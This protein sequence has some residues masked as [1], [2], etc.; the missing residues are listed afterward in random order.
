MDY[1]ARDV[2]QPD[3]AS[4]LD[5]SDLLLTIKEWV[6]ADMD[7]T[8]AWRTQARK[9]FQFVAGPGQWEA[10]DAQIL[11]DQKRP[12]ITFNRTLKFIRAICGLEVNNRQ[13]TTYLPRD[14][15]NEGEVKAN[16]LLTNASDW[17][18]QGCSA[19]RQQSRAFRDTTIC[20]MGWTEGALDYDED[21]KGKYVETRCNP[22]EMGWDCNSRDANLHDAKR[23]WRVREMTL[24]EAQNLIPGVTDVEGLFPEDLDASWADVSD[25]PTGNPK[26]QEQKELREEG[27]IDDSPKRK[28]RIVQIQ[29]WEHEKYILTVNPQTGQEVEVDGDQF[30][31]LSAQYQAVYGI[32]L[33]KSELRRKVYKQA[34]VGGKILSVGPCPRAD[35]FTFNCITGEPEDIEGTFY[36]MVRVFRDPQTYANKF[37]SQ[38]MHIVNTTAKGGII[39]EAD[40]FEDVRDAMKSYAKPDAVTVVRPGAIS[41]GKIMPKPGGALTGGVLQLMQIVDAMF[42]EVSGMNVE[43]MGMA[44]RQQPGVL[45]AQRKQ[46]AMTILATLFD[47]LSQFRQD[48]GRM[49]LFYIQNYLADG[50]LIRVHGED[51][52]KAIPLLQDQTLGRYDVV[53]D[54]APSSVNAKEKAW[55]ALMM[56]LPTVKDMLTPEVVTMLL[57]Y[58]PNLP[59]RVVDQLK[60]IASRPPPEPDP[61]V[62]AIQKAAEGAKIEKDRASAQQSRSAAV[63][64]FAKAGVER[65]QARREAVDAELIGAGLMDPIDADEQVMGPAP[66]PPPLPT[67]TEPMSTPMPEP[68]PADSGL[69]LPG[70]LMGAR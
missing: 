38:L 4:G 33:P 62:V 2:S 58:V 7:H 68:M 19:H 13:M 59:T 48:V 5:D 53:V 20:G 66:M 3:G 63:L 29:W 10:D 43:L 42:A 67:Q 52:H 6:K 39:A 8:S 57:D 22:L 23:R 32:P 11:T 27:S 21:P 30:D 44:D 1:T 40:A 26:T 35:G 18:S 70:G 12:I 65:A 41:K 51:G 61:E 45:E 31:G 34:F 15:A 24:K 46:A 50:R 14:V 47:S 56:L 28:V 69:A 16:E 25:I 60:Q 49:R 54:D 9:D 55:A 36:G 64:N 17:M 37:F